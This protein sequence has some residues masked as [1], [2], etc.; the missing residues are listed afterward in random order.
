MEFE[1]VREY[2]YKY[3]NVEETLLHLVSYIEISKTKYCNIYSIRLYL[4]FFIPLYSKFRSCYIY[5]SS[6]GGAI[7]ITL[8]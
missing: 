8:G 3:F 1:W 5:N 2:L 6:P 7:S 4:N